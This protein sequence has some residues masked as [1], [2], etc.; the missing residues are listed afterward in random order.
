[1]GEG[2]GPCERLSIKRARAIL[3]KV[4]LSPTLKKTNLGMFLKK[5]ILY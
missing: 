2:G 3:E 5:S 4:E 1:M